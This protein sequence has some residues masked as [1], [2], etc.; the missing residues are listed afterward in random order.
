MY[1]HGEIRDMLL[2]AGL[3]LTETYG[4]FAGSEY[5]QDSPRMILIGQKE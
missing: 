2:A 1:S 4:D 3:K 5:T